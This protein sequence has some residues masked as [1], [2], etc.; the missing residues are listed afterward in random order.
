VCVLPDSPCAE[1][2][3]MTFG[4]GATT[5][6]NCSLCKEGTYGTGSGGFCVSDGVSCMTT[7]HR[8][9]AYADGVCFRGG[10]RPQLQ[11][12]R[13]RDLRHRIRS[14]CIDRH[15]GCKSCPDF[16]SFSW[17]LDASHGSIRPDSG[18]PCLTLATFAAGATT[19]VSCSLCESGTYWT[20]SGQD[21]WTEKSR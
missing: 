11:S 12:V 5:R 3:L 10:F 16:A 15:R 2:W 20:G 21:T 14:G 9:G 17:I 18:G 7:C 19:V 1:I 4:A 6:L 13:G 8:P